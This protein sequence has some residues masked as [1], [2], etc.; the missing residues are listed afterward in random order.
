M[1][2]GIQYVDES[3]R[4]V[5]LRMNAN[6]RNKSGYRIA[7]N[8]F[9]NVC[10]GSKFPIQILEKLPSNGYKRCSGFTRAWV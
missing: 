10:P 5:N 1:S 3:V 2:C 9:K 8:Y 4:N 6:R 7:I